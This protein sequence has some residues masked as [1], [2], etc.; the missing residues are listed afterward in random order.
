VRQYIQAKPSF[1]LGAWNSEDSIRSVDHYRARAAVWRSLLARKGRQPSALLNLCSML[2]RV[3]EGTAYSG[4]LQ[5]IYKE[6][7]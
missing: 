2:P 6:A 3:R 5:R 4:V 1:R 7:V